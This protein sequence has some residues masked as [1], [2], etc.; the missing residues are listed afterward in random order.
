MLVSA[1]YQHESAIGALSLEPPSNLPP[2][3]TPPSYDRAPDLNS[4]YHTVNVHR[5]SDFTYGDVCFNTTLSICP[6]SPH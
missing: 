4:L 6:M 1:V 2:H 3:Q 5:L